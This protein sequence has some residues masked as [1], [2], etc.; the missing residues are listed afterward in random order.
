MDKI[1]KKIYKLKL[2][3]TYAWWVLGNMGLVRRTERLINKLK[4]IKQSSNKE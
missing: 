1:E 3:N 4:K 2:M